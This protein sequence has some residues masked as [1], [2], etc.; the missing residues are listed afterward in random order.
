ML[1]NRSGRDA[2]ALDDDLMRLFGGD[3]IQMVMKTMGL[4]DEPLEAGVLT[5]TIENAQKRVE[6]RNFEVRK[7]VLQYDERQ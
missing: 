6:S 1:H 7:Y 3:K 5:K 4:S 2:V